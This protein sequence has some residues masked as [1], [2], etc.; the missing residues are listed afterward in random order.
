MSAGLETR[1]PAPANRI[2]GPT[3]WKLWRHLRDH[4]SLD[5][6][7]NSPVAGTPR[8]FA[9]RGDELLKQLPVAHESSISD[10]EEHREIALLA[11]TNVRRPRTGARHLTF[12]F[13][14]HRFAKPS[15]KTS[16]SPASVCNC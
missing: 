15:H 7:L 2:N 13:L 1:Q 10:C 5:Q 11:V 6:A 16:Q 4:A 3:V 9:S 12:I 14:D 8:Y